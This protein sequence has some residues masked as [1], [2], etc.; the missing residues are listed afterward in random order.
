MYFAGTC[1]EGDLRNPS[2]QPAYRRKTYFPLYTFLYFF[3]FLAC[4]F[5]KKKS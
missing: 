4:T 1:L 3:N 5:K 2:T